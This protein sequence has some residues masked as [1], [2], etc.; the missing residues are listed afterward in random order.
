MLGRTHQIEGQDTGARFD[1]ANPVE[2]QTYSRSQQ[3]RA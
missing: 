3:H 1:I 2:L